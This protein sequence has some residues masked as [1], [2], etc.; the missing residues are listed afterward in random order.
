MDRMPEL[1]RDSRH[2]FSLPEPLRVRFGIPYYP[3][4]PF[5]CERFFSYFA[6]VHG[7]RCAEF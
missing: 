5:L 4:H 3:D 6:H 2:P 1:M 7:L